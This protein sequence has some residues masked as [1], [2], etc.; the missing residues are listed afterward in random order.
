MTDEKRDPLAD[1]P[2]LP[3]LPDDLPELPDDLPD[4]PDLPEI[5]EVAELEEVPE[6]PTEELPQ[7]PAK[8]APA[9]V[10]AKSKPK[11][12]PAPQAK[13]QPPAP[14]PATSPQP[15]ALEEVE[16]PAAAVAEAPA[17]AE[18]TE[19]AAGGGIQL[20][21][22]GKPPLRVLDK[23]PQLVL[24]ASMLVVVGA[25]IPF[26]NATNDEA[27]AEEGG[28]WWSLVAKVLMLAAAW[29]W[30]QQV[31]H[32]WGQPKLTG[33]LAKLGD[34]SL[35]PKPKEEDEGKKKRAAKR[36]AKPGAIDHPFPTALHVLGLLL[37]VGGFVL[38][39]NDPRSSELT[40][41]VAP[42]EAGIFAWAAF[43]FVHIKSYERWGSFNPLFPLM[44]LAML[45]AGLA[46][47]VAGLSAS[48]IWMAARIGGG[49]IVGAGGGLAAYS[50]VEAMMQAKKEGDAKKAAEIERRKAAREAR[51]A[52]K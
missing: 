52:K 48:G 42:A 49:V 18:L 33:F 45:L 51:K 29:V 50:I 22:D 6:L 24:K 28:V 32:N 21:P 19:V 8:P 31:K 7:E 47:V 37:V 40:G 25:L 5:E 3:D 26:M 38:S 17:E 30:M 16:A 9:P 44:F 43:S 12:A 41:P 11:P 2:E 46:S 27:V 23:A 10:V 39:A 20:G 34:L 14:E 1:L 15:A 13:P 35:K 36:D 4:L